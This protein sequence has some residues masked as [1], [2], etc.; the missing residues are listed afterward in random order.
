MEQNDSRCGGAL[1]IRS[2]GRTRS[3]KPSASLY[4]EARPSQQGKVHSTTRPDERRMIAS[5]PRKGA[6][7]AAPLPA[8]PLAKPC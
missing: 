6:A 4:L 2:P 1:L 5:P 8:T 7:A 3:T